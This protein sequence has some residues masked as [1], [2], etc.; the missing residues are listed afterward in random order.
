M[1]TPPTD[2]EDE[3]YHLV[4]LYTSLEGTILCSSLSSLSVFATVLI[5]III[6]RSY[7]GL[8]S[9]YHR[10][11]ML[12]SIANFICSVA[13]CLGTL[14]MPSDM[15][16]THVEGLHIGNQITCNIQ[17]FSFMLGVTAE[18]L[19]F[20]SLLIYY[21]CSITLRIRDSTFQRYMEPV[22]HLV[23]LALSF[24]PPIIALA[25]D[26]INPAIN[27]KN[28]CSRSL[29]PYWCDDESETCLRGEYDIFE[30]LKRNMG[31]TFGAVLSICVISML[32][33]LVS[34]CRLERRRLPYEDSRLQSADGCMDQ[35]VISAKAKAE[36][37]RHHATK[38]IAVQML[39]YL[40][41]ILFV[42]LNS[43]I[44]LY[45][46]ERSKSAAYFHLISR[47]THGVMIC[48]IFVGHKVYEKLRGDETLSVNAAIWQVLISRNEAVYVFD[49]L[50]EVVLE[51]SAGVGVDMN[52]DEALL[53][54]SK[55][56]D[57]IRRPDP[58]IIHRVDP[59]DGMLSFSIPEKEVNE[60]LEEVSICVKNDGSS[61]GSHF[62]NKELGSEP[63]LGGF[64][65]FSEQH[66]AEDDV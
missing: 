38:V 33:I 10:F 31:Y 6:L 41:S 58:V 16:Y 59:L 39:A 65:L 50:D 29:I 26:L 56:V 7:A 21:C 32:L 44:S 1:S 28:W 37:D 30:M 19:Y 54:A 52:G 9:V 5:M 11:F 48:S 35:S 64:S 42:S 62:F 23:C 15:P 49:N 8:S 53:E 55:S 25:G 20:A 2:V 22:L 40:L 36:E 3:R 27:E 61:T 14:P 46:P 4:D 47:P 45:S 57:P 18:T 66:K 60:S 63:S 51:T 34:V 24:T 12:M 17:G 43:Y 13:M